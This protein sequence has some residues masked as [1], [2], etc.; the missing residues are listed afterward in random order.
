MEQAQ[1]RELSFKGRGAALRV[2]FEGAVLPGISDI[3]REL[4]DAGNL[5]LDRQ[6][7]LDFGDHEISRPWLLDLLRDVIFP[8]NLSVT[9]WT[10]TNEKTLDIFASLGL[11]NDDGGERPV[12]TQ[13]TLKIVTTP[14]RSGQIMQHDGDVLMLGNL[15][16]GAEIRATGSIIVIGTL[17]GQVHA[18]CN[19]D[20]SASVITLNYQTNQLRIGSMISNAMDP[21]ASP[22]WGRPVRI[23][24]EGGV[25]V[26]SELP[27]DK[28]R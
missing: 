26:A 15:H 12:V 11:K 21:S 2:G 9:S 25:F 28:E 16:S 4:R 22:W 18:G 24:T 7:I 10:A 5:V 1:K 23:F 3:L 27:R 6:L 8:M 13:G 17:R 19:G 20:D 14:L